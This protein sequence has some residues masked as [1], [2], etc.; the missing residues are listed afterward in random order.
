[1]T[2]ELRLRYFNS[3]TSEEVK[4]L[5][6]DD[7][8]PCDILLCE[9]QSINQHFIEH[10]ELHELKEHQWEDSYGHMPPVST[11]RQRM[12]QK[13][14]ALL[15]FITDFSTMICAPFVDA[16]LISCLV[17]TKQNYDIWSD[18]NIVYLMECMGK[19]AGMLYSASRDWL[20]FRHVLAPS[21]HY[22]LA[23]YY[24]GCLEYI[25]WMVA[26]FS[27]KDPGNFVDLTNRLRSLFK[28]RHKEQNL[29]RSVAENPQ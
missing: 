17:E 13:W 21:T 29:E 12:E 4:Y 10:Y 9:F 15:K 22:P 18:G 23:R 8:M 3:A 20:I 5:Y 1:M 14:V 2:K 28:I 16:N 27:Q 26:S 19:A 25:T 7:F 6:S 24:V 11:Y